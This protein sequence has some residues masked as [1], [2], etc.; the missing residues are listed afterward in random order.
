MQDSGSSNMDNMKNHTSS[1]SSKSS[2]YRTMVART[3]SSQ[4]RGAARSKL[5]AAIQD[6][7]SYSSNLVVKDEEEPA[8]RNY[9]DNDNNSS[10][11]D[12]PLDRDE[13]FRIAS[14]VDPTVDT[15]EPATDEVPLNE[16]PQ[17]LDSQDSMALR[18]A[19][20]IEQEEEEDDG[21]EEDPDGE[22]ESKQDTATTEAEEPEIPYKYLN[23]EEDIMDDVE[24]GN[25]SL[26]DHI[27]E[28]EMDK[29][30]FEKARAREEYNT[31]ER[32][33]QLRRQECLA[34]VAFVFTA[35]IVCVTIG[36]AQGKSTSSPKDSIKDFT[37]Y[38]EPLEDPNIFNAGEVT[39]KFPE[40]VI[41]PEGSKVVHMVYDGP[42]CSGTFRDGA[43]NDI[44]GQNNFVKVGLYT[45]EQAQPR[46]AA[47]MGVFLEWETSQVEQSPLYRRW[48]SN[49]EAPY[50]TMDLCVGLGIIDSDG[51]QLHHEETYILT[52]WLGS[53]LQKVRTVPITPDE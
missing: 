23:W 35:V 26:Y 4:W 29:N 16:T 45:T 10:V 31:R 3:D 14:F 50:G 46:S 24:L 49:G 18:Q 52:T 42:D 36:I 30:A 17:E 11:Q 48:S 22:T 21:D 28:V 19:N 44:T 8:L 53:Y 34:V 7:S 20:N 9:N 38:I 47:F 2:M 43:S 51:N 5:D 40:N 6:G 37:G 1:T 15:V 41:V 33:K 12:A 13:F 32:R 25:D 39:V 27:G